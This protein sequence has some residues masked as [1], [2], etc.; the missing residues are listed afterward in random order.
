MLSLRDINVIDYQRWQL[1]CCLFC[2][3]WLSGCSLSG[4][5]QQAN[6]SASPAK[7]YL[8]WVLYG[9]PHR[10]KVYTLMPYIAYI[11]LFLYLTFH[12]TLPELPP[13]S[14]ADVQGLDTG[15]GELRNHLSRALHYPAEV[16]VGERL[17]IYV[18]LAATTPIHGLAHSC[19]LVIRA[20][21][22]SPDDETHG[23]LG[24][25]LQRVP[26]LQ[27]PI[28]QA[29]L[30]D[31]PWQRNCPGLRERGRRMLAWIIYSILLST[32]WYDTGAW[33][34]PDSYGSIYYM[35]VPLPSPP[36]SSFLYFL[37]WLCR[38][39]MADVGFCSRNLSVI[40]SWLLYLDGLSFPSFSIGWSRY[41]S[42]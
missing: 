30:P 26:V 6:R 13:F 29:H 42:F 8:R 16:A 27:T 12:Q 7:R 14:S 34:S 33:M 38:R 1:D 39:L 21:Q 19:G 41:H 15:K 36:L 37:L 20:A 10:G 40:L 32:Y 9:V 5:S 28:L 18:G 4:R 22:V 23:S 25:A 31:C 2:F 17:N 35:Q 24:A 3:L 11:A